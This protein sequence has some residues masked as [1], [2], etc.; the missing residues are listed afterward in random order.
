MTKQLFSFYF[1]AEPG[2]SRVRYVGITSKTASERLD[3]HMQCRGGTRK[4][5]RWLKRV[6]RPSL[7]VISKRNVTKTKALLL[8][9][10]WIQL[11]RGLGLNLLNGVPRFHR[12]NSKRTRRGR[13][14]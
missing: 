4:K 2:S 9:K 14:K 6:G 5:I 12:K 13:R 8:E 11:F 10:F 3:R 7:I 1:L